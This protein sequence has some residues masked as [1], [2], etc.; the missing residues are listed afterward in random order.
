M[1]QFAVLG[2]MVIGALAIVYTVATVIEISETS[3]HAEYEEN[4]PPR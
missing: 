4:S 1:R 2:A 3:G